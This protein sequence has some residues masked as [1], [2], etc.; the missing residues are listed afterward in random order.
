[1]FD[2]LMSVLVAGPREGRAATAAFCVRL[3]GGFVFV[4]FGVAK[5]TSH[6]SEVA[7]FREYGLPSPEV[8]VAA[9]GVLEIVGGLLLIAGLATRLAALALAGDMV[10]AII[11]SG[12]GEGELISLTLAPAELL[13]MLFLLRA[14]P[15]RAAL[16]HRLA[17]GPS[18]GPRSAG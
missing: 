15:G 11:T 12:I 4:V 10:G 13:G 5:F 7:S 3:A 6:A 14:G 18:V 1:M 2:R 9:I 8:F 16:D 17:R